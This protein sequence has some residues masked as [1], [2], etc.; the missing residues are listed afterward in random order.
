[1]PTDPHGRFLERSKVSLLPKDLGS[2]AGGVPQ[3]AAAGTLFVMGSNGGMRVAPD[4]GFTLLF[5]R[6]ERDVHVCVGADDRQVSRRHGSIT[7]EGSKWVLRNVGK[8]AIRF[9]D[10]QIVL[11]GQY[12]ELPSTYAPLFIVTEGRQHLLEVRIATGGM[13]STGSTVHEDET[14]SPKAWNLSVEERLVLVC[15]AQRYLR[16]EAHPQPMTWSQVA[17]ELHH[18]QPQRGWTRKVAS[19]LVKNVRERHS[20]R[21]AGLLEKEIPPPIGNAL[22]HNLITA[23]LVRGVLTPEDLDLLEEPS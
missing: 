22:N 20:S 7:R 17:E 9:P 12:A 1:M 5:G 2:L 21:V 14:D 8:R 3:A 23:L 13:W 4:A 10:S 15:L 6:S 18:L 11:G 19:H 16:Q